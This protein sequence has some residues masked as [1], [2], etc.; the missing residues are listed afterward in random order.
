M[1]TSE[2][3]NEISA[4]LAKAQANIGGAVKSA[5]NP[6]FKSKYAD[7]ESVWE[8]IRE[9]LTTNGIAVVQSPSTEIANGQTIVSVTTRFVHASGQWI[10]GVMSAI[11]AK[12][13]AQG[14]GSVTSYLRRYALASFASVYQ[15][16]DDGNEAVGNKT[17]KHD[18][19]GKWN[20]ASIEKVITKDTLTAIKTM[21]LGQKAVVALFEK[22]NGDQ[23]LIIA[24]ILGGKK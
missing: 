19:Q 9:P 13:D 16:D 10:E 4:A 6:F 20:I 3:I 11:P 22:H 21:A 15:T 14:I 2:S 17:E 5:A 24:D 1:K 18:Q 12:A 8:A 23:Q 7:L